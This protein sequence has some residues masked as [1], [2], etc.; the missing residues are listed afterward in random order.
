MESVDHSIDARATS[1]C[2]ESSDGIEELAA[3]PQRADA[4]VLE[5]LCRQIG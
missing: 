5:V 3:V 4:K 1:V 2:S